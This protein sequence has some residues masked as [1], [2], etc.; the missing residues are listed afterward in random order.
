LKKRN[1]KNDILTFLASTSQ[2]QDVEKI[3]IE[4]KIGN[5]QTALKHC[6]ELLYDEKIQGIKSSK[7]W[8]FWS[9]NARGIQQPECMNEGRKHPPLMGDFITGKHPH[10]G[11][12]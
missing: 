7:S 9:K 3:R 8:V 10:R 12:A 2:P 5:W 11:R 6:L 4:C 1:Y